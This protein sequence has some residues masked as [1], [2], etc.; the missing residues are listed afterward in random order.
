MLFTLDQI[1]GQDKMNFNTNNNSNN[2]IIII[3]TIITFFE[4]CMLVCRDTETF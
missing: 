1:L 2:Y 4:C 3:I